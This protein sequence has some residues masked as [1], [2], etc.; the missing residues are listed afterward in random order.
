MTTREEHSIE[1]ICKASRYE[2]TTGGK[3][4]RMTE[5]KSDFP[6]IF[7]NSKFEYFQ[8][9]SPGSD[10]SDFMNEAALRSNSS[11]LYFLPT[12]DS[13][14]SLISGEISRARDEYKYDTK[15]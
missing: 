14:I 7:N 3:Y 9:K 4:W 13:M 11:V 8:V 5:V 15:K 1:I 6:A 12:G 10:P 2:T